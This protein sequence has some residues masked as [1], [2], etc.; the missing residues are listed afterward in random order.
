VAKFEKQWI[1]LA[2]KEA[3]GVKA[4]AARLLGLN[5]EKMKYVCR[6]YSL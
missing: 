6:K 5:K 3:D 2:I 1:E 4:H